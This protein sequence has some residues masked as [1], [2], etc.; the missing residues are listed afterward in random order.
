MRT[1]LMQ[2]LDH[3]PSVL[4]LLALFLFWLASFVLVAGSSVWLID[5]P[6]GALAGVMALMAVG[7]MTIATGVL[8]SIRMPHGHGAIPVGIIVTIAASA[9]AAL[10]GGTTG[11]VSLAALTGVA[12][13]PGTALGILAAGMTLISGYGYVRARG[14]TSIVFGI[15]LGGALVVGAAHV[16][17]GVLL[18]EA[19]GLFGDWLSRHVFFGAV[20]IALIALIAS[21]LYRTTAQVATLTLLAVLF[22]VLGLRVDLDGLFLSTIIGAAVALCAAL[23]WQY[24]RYR[25]CVPLPTIGAAGALACI[26][27][28]GVLLP[29]TPLAYTPSSDVRPS[30]ETTLRVGL[31]AHGAQ[32]SALFFGT[33]VGSFPQHWQKVRPPVINQT[34]LWDTDMSTGTGLLPTL[35]IELG[36]PFALAVLLLGLVAGAQSIG[37]G[38]WQHTRVGIYAVVAGSVGL[39][40]WYWIVMHV[41]HTVFVLL[42]SLVLGIGLGNVSVSSATARQ[43]ARRGA[44]IATA[45]LLVT[46][47]IGLTYA[48]AQRLVTLYFYDAGSALQHTEGRQERSIALLE[49]AYAREPAP[50]VARALLD[51]YGRAL[52]DGIA[53]GEGDLMTRAGD[54]VAVASTL[55]RTE[56]AFY[57]N[58]IVLG[59]AYMFNALAREERA[60]LETAMDSYRNARNQAPQHPL[61]PFLEAQALFFAGEMERAR[62]G[63]VEALALRPQYEE[64]RALDTQIEA[65][66]SGSSAATTTG[67]SL[68]QGTSTPT[69]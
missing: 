60:S 32:T 37:V 4:S 28:A 55:V 19:Q 36:I 1:Q 45:L 65:H 16:L 29:Y 11:G 15:L 61:P 59:D 5:T 30:W 46:L 25:T 50:F 57:R 39:F 33:G 41:P 58:H 13:E 67:A 6:L 20:A 64:A 21:G 38:A 42:I 14:A 8:I 63:V 43:S 23:V 47:G 10:S 53:A 66:L 26:I 51:A 3:A 7:A 56:S 34:P 24:R 22:G 52:R 54:M 18:P 2:V 49:R 31:H 69:Q 62:E 68:L 35:S 9:L 40:G 27:C 44:R 12:F 48:G 17:G